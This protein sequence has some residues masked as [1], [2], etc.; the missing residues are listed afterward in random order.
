MRRVVLD[1]F[2]HQIDETNRDYDLGEPKCSPEKPEIRAKAQKALEEIASSVIK[3]NGV[4]IY[5]R[6]H[7]VLSRISPQVYAGR[8]G[9]KGWPRWKIRPAY[10]QPVLHCVLERALGTLVSLPAKDPRRFDSTRGLRKLSA[11]LLKFADSM[12]RTLIE[13]TVAHR[14]IAYYRKTDRP[15]EERPFVLPKEMRW[16]ADALNNVSAR[17]GLIWSKQE[18]SPN[19]QVRFAL[20]II[21]WLTEAAGR[22]Q[23][24]R[25]TT[26]FE[27]AFEAAGRGTPKWVYRLA[28]EMHSKRQRRTAGKAVEPPR[29]QPPKRRRRRDFPQKHSV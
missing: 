8:V 1:D 18:D 28:I 3:K 24:A 14:I 27:A 16:A 5:S 22:P 12:E 21:G 25:L 9:S 19:P 17:T 11:Q 4:A 26:L 15:G 2:L 10:V 23:F 29:N 20:L 6:R 13:R 7:P